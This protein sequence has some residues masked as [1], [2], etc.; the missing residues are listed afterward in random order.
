MALSNF[1]PRKPAINQENVWY[2]K[3]KIADEIR[4]FLMESTKCF[5]NIS[6]TKLYGAIINL[7]TQHF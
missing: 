6:G 5:W 4:L 1:E 3:S 2:G 7:K